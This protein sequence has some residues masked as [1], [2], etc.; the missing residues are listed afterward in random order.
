MYFLLKKI[1]SIFKTFNVRQLFNISRPVLTAYLLP[2]KVRLFKCENDK[3]SH[4]D[5][6]C[7][8]SV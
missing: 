4:P 5:S 6:G 1:L 3:S 8:A 7:V 2:I